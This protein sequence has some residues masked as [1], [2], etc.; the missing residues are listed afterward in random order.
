MVFIR[1]DRGE[2]AEF[3]IGHGQ[4]D[5]RRRRGLVLERGIVRIIRGVDRDRKRVHDS[6]FA[7]VDDID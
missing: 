1:G 2:L 4:G 7:G 3:G 5:G 6:H